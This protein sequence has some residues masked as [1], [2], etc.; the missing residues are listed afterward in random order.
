ML[1][2]TGT[3]GTVYSIQYATN[4][5]ATSFWTDRTLLKVQAGST[6]WSDPSAPTPARRFYRAV[7]VPAPADTNLVFIQ[8][9]TFTMGSPTNEVDRYSDE[10]P[11]TTVTISRGF[12]MGKYEVTQGE[13]LS[14]VGSNPSYFTSANGFPDDPTLPVEKVNRSAANNYCARRTQQERAVGLI[15]TDYVYRL[16]TEAEWEYACRAGTT[17]RFSYGDDPGYTNLTDY[18]W[19]PDNSGGMTHPVGQ[20]LPNPWGLHDIHGN[21]WEWCQD[22]YGVYPSGSVI[23]PQGPA[24]GLF[25]VLRGGAF[26]YANLECRSAARYAPYP[27]GASSGAIGFRVVLGPVQP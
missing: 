26:P 17:T 13:Y 24:T 8:P 18:A 12:W 20:M 27:N 21:V 4:L 5:A 25:G 2:L 23:D 1:S 10:G 16:P 14:V 7:S 15:P 3:V 6:V 22:W 19:G 11:Q 9:G